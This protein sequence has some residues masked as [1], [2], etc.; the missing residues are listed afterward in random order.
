MIEKLKQENERT[1]FVNKLPKNSGLP[2]WDK[3]VFPKKWQPQSF[4]DYELGTGNF[5]IPLTSNGY[6]ISM[7][8][9][10]KKISDSSYT[11]RWFTANDLYNLCYEATNND[12]KKAESLLAYFIYMENV[13]F[14]RTDFYHVPKKIFPTISGE[15]QTDS[16]KYIK[17]KYIDFTEDTNQ[18]TQELVGWSCF[19]VPSGVCN[20][21]SYPCDWRNGC[22]YCSAV[23]CI[24]IENPCP[25]CGGGGGGNGGGN[26]GGGNPGGGTSGGGGNTGGGG[27]PP[28][29]NQPFYL[30]DPCAPPPAP[31]TTILQRLTIYSQAMNST[32]DSVFNLSM[33]TPQKEYG[34]IL[35]KKNGVI[36]PKNIRTDNKPNDVKQN[37]FLQ[38]GEVLLGD[39][40]AHPDA[41]S[42]LTD[43][44]APSDG[45]IIGLNTHG[46]QTRLHYM[47]FIDCGNVRYAL[48]IED[49]AKATLFFRN[50]VF[51]REDISLNYFNSL[52]NNPIRSSNY[53]QAGLEAV[54]AAIGN[55]F[56]N[57]IGIY[58]STNSEKT[59]YEKKN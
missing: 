42:V 12:I 34:F 10:G 37:W 40:H 26:Q 16:T 19:H 58:K 48:V 13:V 11:I 6:S 36:Y 3:L 49:P 21:T 59:I 46:H 20:C 15:S 27:G 8:I 29:C 33:V 22:S 41:S 24:P 50:V 14:D 52:N 51:G 32:A 18:N 9:T 30:V 57:G 38:S 55:T 1:G 47:R 53:Q 35:V 17:L 31:D 56:V 4:N 44:P 2:V 7:I 23:F 28:N 43:R 45:D 5:I 39:W 25:T 54:I